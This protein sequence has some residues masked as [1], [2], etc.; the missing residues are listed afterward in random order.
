[1]N[2]EN[3]K[4]RNHNIPE[5]RKATS[6]PNLIISVLL[7]ILSAGFLYLSIRLR[8]IGVDLFYSMF[9]RFFEAHNITQ[10]FA[11]P[12]VVFWAYLESF[13][14]L[15][16]K[17]YLLTAYV[18]L[19]PAIVMT[20]YAV[21]GFFGKWRAFR[22][23]S[24]SAKSEKIIIFLILVISLAVVLI[25]HYV[26][27]MGFPF[28]NDEYSYLFGSE[29]LSKGKLYAASPPVPAAF[30]YHN[31]I[32]QEKWYSK[33]TIGWPLLLVPGRILHLEGVT[34]PVFAALSL[35]FLYLIARH[36]FGK[37]AGIITA[38]FAMLSPTF[39]FL[40]A[41]FFP[42]TAFG[43][44]ILIF[45]YCA[46]RFEDDK[47]YLYTIAAGLSIFLAINIRPSDGAAFLA[48]SVP[49]LAYV[50]FKSPARKEILKRFLVIAAFLLM[51]IGL[52]LLVNKA[53]NGD[54]FLLSYTKY[55]PQSA[56]GF[57]KYGHTPLHGLW[58]LIFSSMRSCFW[59][60]PFLAILSLFVLSRKNKTPFL[61]LGFI[62]LSVVALNFLYYGVGSIGFG[63]RFY[64]V[65]S[66]M[67]IILA[68]GGIVCLAAFLSRKRIL[69]GKIFI[70]VLIFC[71][72]VYMIFGFYRLV[73]P[74][75]NEVYQYSSS[76]SAQLFSPKELK[77]KALVFMR[78]SQNMTNSEFTRNTPDYDKQ[79]SIVVLYLTPDENDELMRVFKDRIPY[80]A[81]WDSKKMQFVL[82]PYPRTPFTPEDYYIAAL[83]YTVLSPAYKPYAAKIYER[84]YGKNEG[85]FVTRGSA[86]MF[87]YREG[88]YEKAARIFAK[89]IRENP[90]YDQCYFFL[91][92]SLEKMGQKREA[93]Q[94]FQIIIERFPES[95]Y[96]N[97]SK[98][99]LRS[100]EESLDGQ[101][102]LK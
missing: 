92:L 1:M 85:N 27:M 91:G 96:V 11:T 87:F 44:V 77:H 12:R 73:T 25:V 31:I 43:L 51:G 36:F 41:S 76:L 83:N 53:Q 66:L 7:L 65:S 26:V 78:S 24:Y 75:V 69:P 80:V 94:V 37:R 100:Y 16:A 50:F 9:T 98:D 67:M 55:D 18:L 60:A 93:A 68:S 28:T 49:L 99:W 45:I 95:K 40:G 48:G 10:D 29:L 90:R 23:F 74:L 14:P 63:N 57:G 59:M 32:C 21:W 70:P 2:K 52:I 35:L 38:F 46:L 3:K 39:V 71:I 61:Q 5:K 6:A 58:N 34:A 89:M 33:Y 86:G 13:I 56:V 64:Y 47:K 97:Q 15:F 81:E 54:Y 30:G 82:Q 8:N 4:S 84:L 72:S 42:H 20:T 102:K 62:L 22:L 17:D 88:Q 19:A 79:Q 101:M